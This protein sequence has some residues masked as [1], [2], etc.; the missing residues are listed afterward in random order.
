MFHLRPKVLIISIKVS[1]HVRPSEKRARTNGLC[2]HQN[3]NPREQDL[4]GLE[5]KSQSPCSSGEETTSDGSRQPAHSHEI[6]FK[7]LNRK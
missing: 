3:T 2:P 7:G 5:A 4:C 6:E 1:C